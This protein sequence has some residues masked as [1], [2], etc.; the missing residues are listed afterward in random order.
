MFKVNAHNMARN[1]KRT[2]VTVARLVKH[3]EE[4]KEG[5]EVLRNEDVRIVEQDNEFV[6]TRMDKIPTPRDR[7]RMEKA[8][9][10]PSRS[11]L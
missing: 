5:N 1:S 3:V 4:L 8:H 9:R 11:V 6:T 2:E 10:N 7:A